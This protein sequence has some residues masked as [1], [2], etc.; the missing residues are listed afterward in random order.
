[1]RKGFA[2]D[3]LGDYITA[4]V[5]RLSKRAAGAEKFVDIFRGKIYILFI[6]KRFFM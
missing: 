6:D 2:I 4:E 3:Y 5:K 1:M